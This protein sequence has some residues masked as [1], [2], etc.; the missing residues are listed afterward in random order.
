MH[1]LATICGNVLHRRKKDTVLTSLETLKQEYKEGL[2]VVKQEQ[3][4]G[5]QA[6]SEKLRNSRRMLC[7]DRKK[8]CST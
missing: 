2:D 4:D 6:L 5:Q 3:E 7:L 8:L 1:V